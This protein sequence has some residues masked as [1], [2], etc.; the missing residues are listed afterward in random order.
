MLD[1]GD[2]FSRLDSF[3]AGKETRYPLHSRIDGAYSLSG[4]FGEEKKKCFPYR[5]SNPE[6][7]DP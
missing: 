3:I 6:S 7:S 5:N 2:W 1:G 4:C